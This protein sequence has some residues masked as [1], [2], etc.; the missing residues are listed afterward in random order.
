MSKKVVFL[1][2]LFFATCVLFV[3]THKV[4]AQP[5]SEEGPPGIFHQTG[6][7]TLAPSG[8]TGTKEP[9]GK[10]KK[11]RVSPI[12]DLNG[13]HGVVDRI[14]QICDEIV[15]RLEKN[16][17]IPP[18]VISKTVELVRSF[19]HGHHEKLEDNFL[20]PRLRQGGKLVDLTRILEQQHKAGGR[21]LEEI[22]TLEKMGNSGEREKMADAF[23]S[24]VR[25]YRP[26]KAMEDTIILP[27]F[28][29]LVPPAEYQALGDEFEEQE[30]KLFG[31]GAF[32]KILSQVEAIE[33]AL[34]IYELAQFTPNKF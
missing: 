20:F 30:E 14:L 3:S 13:E 29:Q 8:G 22:L 31:K 1:V 18:E 12:E 16:V 26:H 9:D 24:F 5:A 27:A 6:S 25:M 33:V 7:N 4:S 23:R 15:K 17:V 19:V 34:G 2:C 21:L 32:G 11:I 28:H 10:E